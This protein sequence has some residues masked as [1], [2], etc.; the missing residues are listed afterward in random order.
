MFFCVVLP[1]GPSRSTSSTKLRP[2]DESAWQLSALNPACCKAVSQHQ[3]YGWHR[4]TKGEYH[5]RSVVGFIRAKMQ[6]SRSPAPG[7]SG[8]ASESSTSS[9]PER[10]M[11]DDDTDFFMHQ[12]NDSQSSI[13]VGNLRD[14]HVDPSHNAVRAPVNRLP[15]ELLIA[16]FSKLSS[17]P[18]DMLSCMQVSQAWA[19]NCVGIL[20]HRPTCSTWDNLT[21]VAS[22]VTKPKSYFQ[23]SAMIKR[24]NM[25]SLCEEINDGTILPFASCKRIERL[26]LT[27]CRLLTD[28]G[29]SG[30]I[31]GNNHLQALDVSGIRSLTDHTL[32]VVARDCPRLQ[33]LNITGCTEITDDSL[34]R[35]A[36]SCRQ[37]KRVGC[38]QVA[39]L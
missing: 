4:A 19:T 12:V 36:Q 6:R 29:I 10:T 35:L 32:S 18:A 20:W 25:S 31:Q 30:V 17:S 15:P 9:S 24:L 7:L 27:S 13:G 2:S 16:I 5:I 11:N 26:T 1:A 3:T 8:V 34:I 14:L 28:N 39:A 22:S 23:Y 38:P 37:L 33:G 21:R